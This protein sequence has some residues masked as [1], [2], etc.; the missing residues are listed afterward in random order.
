M[1]L[2]IGKTYYIKNVATGKYLNVYGTDTV[3]NS[4]N[5]NTYAK[6][7]CLAQ[8]W[9]VGLY[10]S[11]A[12]VYTAINS[13]YALNINTSNNNCT[14]YLAASNSEADSVVDFL[15][16]SAS[17]NQYR[18]KMIAHNKFLS[19]TTSDSNAYWASSADSYSLW[20]LEEVNSSSSIVTTAP[21]AL[22]NQ[23]F[24]VKNFNT[25]YNLNVSGYD[26]VED[27]RNVNVYSKENCLAQKWIVRQK[28]DGAKLCTAINEAY[29]L[30]INR[31]TN[32]CSMYTESTNDSDDC[33]LEFIPYTDATVTAADRVY[34]IKMANHN[35]YLDPDAVGDN[36][37]VSWRESPAYPLWQFV[38]EADMFPTAPAAPSKIVGSTFAIKAY[39]TNYNLNVHG[40]DTVADE[41]NVTIYS[42]E[43][44]LAQ[45]WVVKNT[46]TGPKLYTKINE[47]FAL[48]IYTLDNNC[49][50][51]TDSVDND[52]DSILE[53]VEVADMLYRIKLFNH[54]KYLCI[55]GTAGD[56]ANVVWA[57][58]A[59]SANLWEFIP[60]DT[61]FPAAAAAPSAIVGQTFFIKN[62]QTGYNL[63]VHGTDTVANGR[64]VN[65]YSKENCLAQKWQ[66]IQTAKGPKI[67]TAIDPTFALNIYSEDNPN[68]TMYK[69]DV[70]AR[71]TVL[72]FEPYTDSQVTAA[73]KVYMIKLFHHGKYL[74]TEGVGSGYNVKWSEEPIY[75]LWQFVAEEEMFPVAASAPE[76]IADK[77]FFIQ[78]VNTGYY[79]NVHG[80]DTVANTRNVNV[81][82]KEDVQAQR[83]IIRNKS[84]GPKLVTKI[85][86]T[87]AVNIYAN[88][89]NCTMYTEAGNDID[90]VLQFIPYTD[91]QTVASENIYR[92]KMHY[93][94]CYLTVANRNIGSNAYWA[95]VDTEPYALWKLIPESEMTFETTTPTEADSPLVTS[96]IPAASSNYMVG[97]N[98]RQ[99]SEITIHHMA[100][101]MSV[102]RL[103]AM[104]Q[105]STRGASSHYGVHG[106][107]IGQYVNE[108]DTAYTNGGS[109]IDPDAESSNFR[110]V[111]IETANIG[112]SDDNWPVSDDTLDTLVDL[113][114]DIARRNSLGTLVPGENL[115]WHSMYAYTECPG[116]YL[117]SKMQEIADRANEI[118][119]AYISGRVYLRK[120]NTDKFF[121]VDENSHVILVDKDKAKPWLLKSS[122]DKTCVC[123][124]NN[125]A[126]KINVATDETTLILSEGESDVYASFLT[127]D[128]FNICY[129][130]SASNY[131]VRTNIITK[132]FSAIGSFF[133]LSD[134]GESDS[135]DVVT[136]VNE[137]IDTVISDIPNEL[138]NRVVKI[139]HKVTGK[140]LTYTEENGEYTNGYGKTVRLMDKVSD[141]SDLSQ[142][143]KITMFGDDMYCLTTYADVNH[144][145]EIATDN[146]ICVASNPGMYIP[147]SRT[148]SVEKK[149]SDEYIIQ[150]PSVEKNCAYYIEENVSADIVCGSS[151]D[152]YNENA[153]WIIEDPDPVT[154]NNW[155]RLYFNPTSENGDWRA[156]PSVNSFDAPDGFTYSF[157]NRNEWFGW[158]NPYGNDKINPNVFDVYTPV[159]DSNVPGAYEDGD[160]NYWV[161]VGPKVPFKDYEYGDS[162]P[163]LNTKFYNVGKLDAVVSDSIGNWYYI[164]CVIGDIK[165]HS[166]H[167]GIVQTWWSYTPRTNEEKQEFLKD[168]TDEVI[169]NEY[170]DGTFTADPTRT[171]DFNGVPCIEFIGP[172]SGKTSGISD[173]KIEHI[174]FYPNTVL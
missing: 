25:G 18:I 170:S 99:I 45:R 47:N 114:A 126:L 83:W 41:R 8:K 63:N 90:S 137:E 13:A 121:S 173:Y 32:N 42:K 49:T 97:R 105:D 141:N 40:S 4:R 159:I 26:T 82:A 94:N 166:Y 140:Y 162:D 3:A 29:A 78:N 34:K 155:L 115:T 31:N 20:Q 101:N 130:T 77:V 28:S 61:M 172:L 131:A 111:T 2:E 44:C 109:V 71:D 5:V 62:F 125:P 15:T 154:K 1:A 158:E 102:Q 11:G 93:H 59:S 113:V 123:D 9:T 168:V 169:R 54:N 116:N 24:F 86:E 16:V 57:E 48:N 81:Y 10:G 112:T 171:K 167:N 17:N 60:E 80:T 148:I 69:A 75:P 52:N 22:V 84:G 68:C 91:E 120:H 106:K 119:V 110:A 107:Q 160:G 139:K 67:I 135:V 38:T 117:R 88:D 149:A 98:G 153:L 27:E 50:M 164:P 76:E 7:D 134:S 142:I 174:L 133:G 65:V 12:R 35:R 36:V 132:L 104:W 150:F 55:S 73:D 39:G 96:F 163:N 122:G 138:K 95:A 51:H 85:N 53:F 161:A 92:I 156:I 124:F 30:N 70:S 79:L 143:W 165:G 74:T 118:N 147:N 127:E 21:S 19:V 66:V 64:N 43:D 72:V 23:T 136:D 129:D 14:M 58:G 152:N 145:L 144:S 108:C 128:T 89:N 103:G 46:A 100:G 151:I 37:N 157:N 6:E 33:V 146:N 87:F 56:G